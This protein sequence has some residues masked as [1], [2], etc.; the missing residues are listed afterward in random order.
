MQLEG[1]Q[2][3]NAG[4]VHL[5]GLTKLTYLDLG[6]TQATTESAKKP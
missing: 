1:A 3:A 4:L 5:N 2:V 6:A